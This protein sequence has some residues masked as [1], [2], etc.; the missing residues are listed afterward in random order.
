MF[1][2]TLILATLFATL[3][4]PLSTALA[5]HKCN[6]AP[7]TNVM[8]AH[9]GI[10]FGMSA[11]NAK[12]ALERMYGNQALVLS[13]GSDIHVKF[14]KHKQEIFDQIALT[15][16]NGVVI[17]MVWSY[18]NKFQDSL[19]GP[20]PALETVLGKL[21][22]KIGVFTNIDQIDKGAKII[23]D[24]KD[25]LYLVLL[26]RDPY[27]IVLAFTCETLEDELQK[28]AQNSANLGF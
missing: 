6:T 18:S 15:T 23:W 20:R 5:K 2:K 7:Y 12:A 8:P 3:L 28:K 1:R 14:F 27:T 24:T 9:A 10:T 11:K 17:K 26:G 4:N 13:K 21:K 16:L 19:G 22:E 25:D